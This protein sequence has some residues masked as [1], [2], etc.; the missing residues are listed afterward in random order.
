MEKRR[1]AGTSGNYRAFGEG[2]QRT[3]RF[4]AASVKHR[5][6][7]LSAIAFDSFTLSCE[8]DMKRNDSEPVFG[9]HAKRM[10][11]FFSVSLDFPCFPSHS[12]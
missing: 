9:M 12:L 11:K 5:R 8:T 10:E 3:G 4:L 2:G 1:K 6:Y 7:R